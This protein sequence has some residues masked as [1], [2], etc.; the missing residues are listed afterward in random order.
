MRTTT[1]GAVIVLL[2]GAVASAHPGDHSGGAT[3]GMLH[4]LLG[5]DHL[6]VMLG[7]GL[8]AAKIGGRA[9]WAVPALFLMAMLC[10]GALVYSGATLPLVEAG[11]VTSV[12]VVGLLL[13]SDWRLPR[14]AKMTLVALSA[15]CHGAAHAAEAPAGA[16][17]MSY[18]TGFVMTTAALHTAGIVAGIALNQAEQATTRR[19]VFRICG[20]AMAGCAALLAVQMI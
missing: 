19:L 2:C 18:A 6:L 7:I 17:F 15:I 16:S 10:G 14:W 4:P 11:I 13:L 3:A 1:I 12:L 9:V 20:G 5:L 8:W